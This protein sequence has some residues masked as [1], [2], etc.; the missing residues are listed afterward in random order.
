MSKKRRGILILTSSGGSGHIQAAKAKE[1]EAKRRYPHHKILVCDLMLDWMG[2]RLGRYSVYRWNSAQAKGDVE[3]QIKL[4]GF[5]R[6]SELLFWVP[7]FLRAFST[8]YRNDIELIIDTQPLFTPPIMKAARLTMWLKN[9]KIHMEKIITE[10]PTPYCYHFFDPIKRLSPRDR[11]HI[12]LIT[13]Y[14]LLQEGRNFWKKAC[15]LPSYRIKYDTP[16][17]R[18][19]FHKYMRKKREKKALTLNIQIHSEEEAKLIEETLQK[20]KASYVFSSNTLTYNIEPYARVYTLMLG[21]I[22][23]ECNTMRYIRHILKTLRKLPKDAEPYHL[24]VFCNKHKPGTKSLLKRVH[25]LIT[26]CSIYPKQLT[27]IPMTFQDDGVIAPLFFRSDATFTR[28]GGLT[29]MELMAVAKGQICIH[30]EADD[31]TL[32]HYG[33]P[34]WEFGNAFYLQEKRGAKILTADCFE[35]TCS[36]LFLDTPEKAKKA[37]RGELIGV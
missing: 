29:S 6:L 31:L 34:K 14:P 17:L 13:F 23:A 26:T 1:Y 35:R 18:P 3:E 22:P 2:K 30:S 20:G 5:Q 25:D 33:M 32:A 8:L 27:V 12:D 37:L 19:T 28:S 10:L 21:S 24:F 7:I 16:P 11:K 9:R 36:T 4:V 15:N